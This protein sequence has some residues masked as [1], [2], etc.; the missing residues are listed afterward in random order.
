MGEW[1]EMEEMR[2][3]EISERRVNEKIKDVIMD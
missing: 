1:M 2:K 3:M